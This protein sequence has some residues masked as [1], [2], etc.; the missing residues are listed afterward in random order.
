MTAAAIVAPLLEESPREAYA[1]AHLTKYQRL[2]EAEASASVWPPT[3]SLGAPHSA[4]FQRKRHC[5]GHDDRN[6]LTVEPRRLVAPLLD[7]FDRRAV[8]HRQ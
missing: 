5:H 8:E 2:T 6:R 1:S 3:A 4:L 7:R